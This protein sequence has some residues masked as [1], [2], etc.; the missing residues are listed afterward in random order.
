MNVTHTY[1]NMDE[2]WRRY[3]EQ[4][5]SDT[6]KEKLLEKTKLNRERNQNSGCL[7]G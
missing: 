6:K 3:A 1:N 7:R 4:K 2:R 5:T